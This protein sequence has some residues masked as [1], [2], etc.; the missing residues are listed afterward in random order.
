MDNRQFKR[1]IVTIKT[2][3]VYGSLRC[4]GII[5]NISPKGVYAVATPADASLDFTPGSVVDLTFEFPTG[6]KQHLQCRIKWS[7]KTPPH[8]L[9]KSIGM[10]IIDAPAS[11]SKL[12]DSME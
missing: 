5:E 11:F 9:T 6:E 3:L 1:K 2:E 12:L 4:A 8:E 7:Y 10:E